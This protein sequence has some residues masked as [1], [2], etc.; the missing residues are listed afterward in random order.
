MVAGDGEVEETVPERSDPYGDPEGG[1]EEL[2][3]RKVEKRSCTNC[4]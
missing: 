4:L 2:Q 1:A 3:S